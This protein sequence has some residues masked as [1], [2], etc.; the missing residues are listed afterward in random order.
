MLPQVPEVTVEAD[1]KPNS[2]HQAEQWSRVVLTPRPKGERLAQHH[3]IP[4]HYPVKCGKED[5]VL[6]RGKR[7]RSS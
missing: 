4:R 6:N 3:P 7:L 5:I 2:S 1:G